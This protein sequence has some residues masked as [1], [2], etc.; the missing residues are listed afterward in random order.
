MGLLVISSF[1]MLLATL[2]RIEAIVLFPASCLFILLSYGDRKGYR[3]F[4][5]LFP[6]IFLGG[7][8]GLVAIKAGIDILSL[9]RLDDISLKISAPF[10]SYHDLRDNV[11]AIASMHRSNPFG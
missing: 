10:T 8:A 1:L 11:G 7:V 3:L 4:G 2:T 6:V 5:F 9:A